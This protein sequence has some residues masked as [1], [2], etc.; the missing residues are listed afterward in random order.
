MKSNEVFVPRSRHSWSS[1]QSVIVHTM[2]SKP[3]RRSIGPL[4]VV[5]QRPQKVPSHVCSFPV[6]CNKH[7]LNQQCLIIITYFLIFYQDKKKSKL[8]KFGLYIFQTK[9]G[10]ST[11]HCCNQ[12]IQISTHVVYSVL[13]IDPFIN[14]EVGALLPPNSC[15]RQHIQFKP[16]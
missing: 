12:G 11:P 3:Y 10:I 14:G 6:P 16:R 4:K 7:F 15:A 9:M 2:K 1:F 8:C 13:I 5:K